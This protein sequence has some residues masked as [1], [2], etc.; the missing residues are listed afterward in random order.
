[1]LDSKVLP[2]ITI[3]TPIGDPSSITTE[4]GCLLEF[5][6]NDD[7]DSP[8]SWLSSS[9]WEIILN[10]I[11]R[12]RPRVVVERKLQG[13]VVDDGDDMNNVVDDSDVV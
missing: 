6:D 12:Y 11:L 1:M 3:A 7:D 10:C 8:F 9:F 5:D 4:E 13:A 2:N